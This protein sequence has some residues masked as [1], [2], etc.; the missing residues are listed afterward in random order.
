[1][2]Q[3]ATASNVDDF[4]KFDPAGQN[5]TV[6]VDA[7]GPGTSFASVPFLTLVDPTGVPTGGG[8]AQAAVNN[9]ALVV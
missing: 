5:V 4:V 7:D 2:L 9:G 1:V 8:A 6:S 3:G